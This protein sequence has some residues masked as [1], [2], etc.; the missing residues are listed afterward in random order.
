[1][2]DPRDDP[3]PRAKLTRGEDDKDVGFVIG[4]TGHETRRLLDVGALE[5]P[6][7]G[8]VPFNVEESGIVLEPCFDLFPIHFHGD[9]GVVG[10][11]ELLR[12]VA[13]GLPETA[14]HD[15]AGQLLD[16]RFQAPLPHQLGELSAH[17]ERRRGGDPVGQGPNAS[18]QEKNREHPAL[19]RQRC[20]DLPVS[21]RGQRNDRHVKG[22]E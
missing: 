14:H 20:R 1:M 7:V 17:Q 21:H 15:V 12:H 18:K 22:V 13:P 2:N 19:N 4:Q 6:L 11:P 8:G 16:L 5:A 3:D 10:V 9:K